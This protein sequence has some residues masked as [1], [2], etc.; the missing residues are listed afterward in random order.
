MTKKEEKKEIWVLKD[1][2]GDQTYESIL[3]K[4]EFNTKF[5]ESSRKLLSNNISSKDFLKIITVMEETGSL[6]SRL[7][8]FYSLKSSENTKDEEALAKLSHL[9]MLG[10]D[11]STRT[12]FLDLWFI[13]L[14]DDSALRLINS[15]EL[16]KYKFYLESMREHKPYTKSEEVEKILSL[17]DVTGGDAFSSLYDIHVSSFKFDFEGKKGL[18]QEELMTNYTSTDPKKREAAYKIIYSKYKEESVFLSEMYKSIVLDWYNESIKIRGYK[19]SISVRNMSNKIKDESLDL[20]FRVLRKNTHIFTEYFKLKYELLNKK[21]QKCKFSRYHIY[22]PYLTKEKKYSYEESK[23]IVLETFNK[24]DSRFYVAAKKVFDERHVHSHPSSGKRGGAFCYMINTKITPYVLLN[25]TGK[26]KDVT[27]MMHELGHAV[28]DI[29]SAKQIE[30]L[31]HPKI[32]LA[33]TASVFAETMLIKRFISQTKS[34][35]EKIA[36]L[37]QTIDSHYQSIPRQA[38]LVL[39]EIWAHENI[40]E[41]VTKKEMDDYYH[42]LLVEQF[43]DMEIPEV[44]DH[45]WNYIPHIHHTPFYT[46]SYAWGNLLVLSLYALYKEEGA[47]FV[48]KYVEFL[49][50][51]SS[52]STKDIMKIVGADP[53]LEEFWQKGFD[54]IKEEL[55]EL[56]RLTR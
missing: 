2:L 24:F 25:Y 55:E 36:L 15:E 12:L 43:G 52:K 9:S 34:K 23:K 7:S 27:T 42:S 1:V 44:F 54:I 45:E 8:A 21:G 6:F 30:L 28:H 20:F 39:F 56:K 11:F 35:E 40:K 5:M 49:S 41:G 31:A 13:N 10:S 19:S 17:K 51:G 38:Y 50:A 29:F 18:T 48:N 16:E 22:A 4:I 53:D 33:E 37:V 46:Y 32:P 47:K 26:Y 3:K 14:N